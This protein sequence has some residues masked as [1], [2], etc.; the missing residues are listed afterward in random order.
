MTI[1]DVLLALGKALGS[2]GYMG[3]VLDLSIDVLGPAPQSRAKR[4]RLEYLARLRVLYAEVF[5]VEALIR[6]P[7]RA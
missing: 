3:E 6:S 2:A 5:G 4:R 7:H 1:D